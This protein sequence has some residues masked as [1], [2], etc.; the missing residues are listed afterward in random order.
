MM[1]AYLSLGSNIDPQRILEAALQIL[2][3]TFTG[4]R[5]SPAYRSAALGF[6]GSD[7]INLA[8][9]LD[10][11]LDPAALQDWLH[12]LEIRLGRDR[13]APRFS[14]HTLDADL[15]AYLDPTATETSPQWTGPV[16]CQDYVLKPLSDIA[17]DL[18]DPQSGL[19]LGELWHQRTD[20]QRLTRLATWS[21]PAP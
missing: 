17:P 16:L 21:D 5:I 1:R 6:S 14:N 12:A 11:E 13:N 9:R 7:F 10:T 19:S 3:S 15:L 4:L 20:P 18:R 2:R 8:V